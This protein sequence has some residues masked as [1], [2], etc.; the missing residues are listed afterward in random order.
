M[1]WPELL[2][3]DK[4]LLERFFFYCEDFRRNLDRL[5][6]FRSSL[7]LLVKNS[8]SGSFK[9]LS[10]VLSAQ[11]RAIHDTALACQYIR[12][13]VN[14]IKDSLRTRATGKHGNAE[15]LVH[16]RVKQMHEAEERADSRQKLSTIPQ[17]R[18]DAQHIRKP[19]DTQA[20]ASATG[21]NQGKFFVRALRDKSNSMKKKSV[22]FEKRDRKKQ[23]GQKKR[24]LASKS[25]YSVLSPRTAARKKERSTSEDRSQELKK[26]LQILAEQN[27][28]ECV[29]L[30]TNS[31]AIF[32]NSANLQTMKT[33]RKHF[34]P[35][36]QAKAAR[37]KLEI[38]L[39]DFTNPILERP[40]DWMC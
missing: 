11:E 14:N 22:S 4:L 7:A 37:R 30:K 25:A 3:E 27:L 2:S 23:K 40:H 19:S 39:D 15:G 8:Q 13:A 6:D 33:A 38:T 35:T 21:H 28:S 5:I 29:N 12:D 36:A 20:K 18:L 31:T 24:G 16:Q 10:E 17:P 1:N 9:F 34:R 32:A 26:R